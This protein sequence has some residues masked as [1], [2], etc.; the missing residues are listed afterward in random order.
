MCGCGCFSLK[1]MS[2]MTLVIVATIVSLILG[3]Q[4][5][6][7]EKDLFGNMLLAVGQ[8]L[9]LMALQQENVISRNCYNYN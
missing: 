6:A 3:C 1:N 2:P 9:I 8:L 4:M 7:E 5:D